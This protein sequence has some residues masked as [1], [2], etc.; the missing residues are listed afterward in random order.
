MRRESKVLGFGT[1]LERWAE[2]GGRGNIVLVA[3]D[4]EWISRA[5]KAGQDS[6]EGGRRGRCARYG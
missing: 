5:H 2:K 6:E 3:G 1:G 4:G